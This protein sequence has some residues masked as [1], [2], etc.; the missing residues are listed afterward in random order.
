MN[1]L[2]RFL[3]AR[4]AR[5]LGY[6]FALHD[7]AALAAA[8]EANYAAASAG[9]DTDLHAALQ[10]LTSPLA[11]QPGLVGLHQESADVVVYLCSLAA[12]AE[13]NL[14]LNDPGQYALY[15]E[16]LDS[17]RAAEELRQRVAAAAS[18]ALPVAQSSA[19]LQHL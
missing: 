2:L 13:T 9:H 12:A 16:L 4:L 15:R 1:R 14:D 10:K 8:L 17:V 19:E 3:P 11:F 7:P 18:R 5:R 6:E